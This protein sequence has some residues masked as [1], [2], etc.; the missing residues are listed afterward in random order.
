MIPLIEYLVL[1]ILGTATG[2]YVFDLLLTLVFSNKLEKT[3]RSQL[4]K[5][6]IL[7]ALLAILYGL[8]KYY[9]NSG[10][11]ASLLSSLVVVISLAVAFK[12]IN[13]G[14]RWLLQARQ[15][16]GEKYSIFLHQSF[17]TAVSVLNN[18]VKITLIFAALLYLLKIWRIDI[19]PLLA[20]AGIAGIIIGFALKDILENIFAGI[21][22]LLD[23]PFNVGD[24]VE[25]G[26]KKGRIISIGIR[27][28]KIMLFDNTVISIPNSEVINSEIKNYT[29]PNDIVKIV[30]HIGTSY[31]DDPERV[32]RIILET[33]K[34]IPGVLE[35]PEP[36]VFFVEFGDF[37]L[38][39][40]IWV[41]VKFN[42]LYSIKD[43]I[44]TRLWKAL[45]EQG[46]EIPYPIYTVYLR[47]SE[48]S[49]K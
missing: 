27:N 14:S 9:I 47:G 6:Y 16:Y 35:Y 2:Y 10:L 28:T 26:D 1:A 36:K 23:P 48:D 19:T 40:E 29:M 49:K 5:Y 3:L 34:Q 25:I 45:R 17:E 13:Y 32:K 43:A 15:H 41:W 38:I 42:D 31:D 22:L 21:I 7:L 30:L 4:L 33:V 20:S 24:V 18:L 8:V 12:L 46:V 44:N 37:A 39:Y 11:A